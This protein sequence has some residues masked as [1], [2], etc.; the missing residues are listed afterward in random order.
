MQFI[1]KCIKTIPALA[2]KLII[3]LSLLFSTV[4][5]FVCRSLMISILQPALVIIAFTFKTFAAIGPDIWGVFQV[6]PIS[7]F[8]ML[9]FR[10]MV[11]TDCK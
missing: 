10:P 11:S 8:A 6:P 9:L 1:R 2:G 5:W 4:I 3:I 7:I